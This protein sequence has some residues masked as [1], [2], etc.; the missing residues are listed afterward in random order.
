M[1]TKPIL[2]LLA[3]ALMACSKSHPPQPRPETAD[4]DTVAA[5]DEGYTFAQARPEPRRVPPRITKFD[6]NHDGVL[7]ASEVPPRLKAWFAEVDTNH[8]GIVTAHEI[9]VY[10]RAHRHHAA[11]PPSPPPPSPPTQHLSLDT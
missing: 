8:D 11:P 9:R 6:S 2:T 5:D 4:D 1:S 10:N 7:E 3:L